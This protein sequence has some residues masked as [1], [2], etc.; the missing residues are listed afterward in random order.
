MAPGENVRVK[1]HIRK[2]TLLCIASLAG[3]VI[4][5]V[6]KYDPLEPIW[7]VSSLATVMCF[8]LLPRI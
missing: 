1:T 4:T 8:I 7:N 5:S 3:C 2:H 6:F